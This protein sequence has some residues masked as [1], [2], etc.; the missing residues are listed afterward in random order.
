M[1]RTRRAHKSV[2]SIAEPV[3]FTAALAFGLVLSGVLFL[4]TLSSF[5]SLKA[6]Q[7]AAML[8]IQNGLSQEQ[9]AARTLMGGVET[10]DDVVPSAQAASSLALA[11]FRSEPLTPKAHAILALA[12]SN[13]ENRA[14]IL[15]AATRINRR[16]LLLQGLILEEQVKAGDYSGSLGTLDRLL[17]VHTEQE[18]ALFPVL[19]RALEQQAAL[20]VLGEILDGSA[21]WHNDFLDFAVRKPDALS[22]LADL[23]ERADV[24]SDEFERRL[25]A[26]LAQNNRTDRAYRLFQISSGKQAASGG[27]GPIDWASD[28]A[29]FDWKLAD[30]RGLRAQESRR[31]GQLD[32]YV[33]SGEGGLIAERLIRTPSGRFGVKI[34]HRIMPA[35][36]IPDVRLQLRCAGS[37]TPFFDERFVRGVKVFEV[38][39]APAGCGFMSIGIQARAWSGRSALRGT[40]D[41]LEIVKLAALPVTSDTRVADTEDATEE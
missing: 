37:G 39:A 35:D 8:P 4:Q 1:R 21:G 15:A 34:G 40:V 19:M 7:V 22:A 23:R 31:E 18:A 27:A 9:L 26:G 17:K 32:I 20:P 29:P 38:G 5:S 28:F 14:R 12:E 30:D 2:F 6:P 3:R 25:I 13:A 41:Q 16:D 24:G 36:Q 10:Q 33:R 11:A